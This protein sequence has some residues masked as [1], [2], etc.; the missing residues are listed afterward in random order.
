[1]IASARPILTIFGNG[2]VREI[3]GSQLATVDMFRHVEATML[4]DATERLN[5]ACF[6]ALLLDI[7]LPD[8][9]G[10]DF[11]S[12]LRSLGYKMPILFLRDGSTD[13]DVVRGLDAGANDYITD[14]T[15]PR[16]LLARLRAQLR[17][18][19][20]SEDATLT[21][22]S[23]SFRP[24]EKLLFN[25]QTNR[26]IRL[27]TR[28][29]DLLKFLHQTGG[30]YVTRQLLLREVWG[31]NTGSMSRTLDTHIYK[32][33][34]KMSVDSRCGVFIAMPGG[35]RLDIPGEITTL[36]PPRASRASAA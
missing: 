16:E 34:K 4:Y 2:A 30:S 1:M 10:I 11:C 12:T 32:L 20:D 29:V 14:T 31:Y 26:R 27:T 13:T 21:I 23:F 24:P 33:R 6:D 8:G 9:N 25:P 19:D 15:R 36:R 18:F 22:G 17:I 7:Q 3:V 5:E 35:Y 28:E